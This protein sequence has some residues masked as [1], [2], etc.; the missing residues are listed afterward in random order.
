MQ[1]L[2]AALLA[3]LIAGCGGADPQLECD[4]T[5]PVCDTPGYFAL[6]APPGTNSAVKEFDGLYCRERDDCRPSGDDNC[7]DYVGPELELPSDCSGGDPV[8]CPDGELPGC[9]FLASC[10]LEDL[11]E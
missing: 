11:Y 5:Q 10:A 4:Q 6:C 9:Y 3:A 1:V 7:V 8:E 2:R